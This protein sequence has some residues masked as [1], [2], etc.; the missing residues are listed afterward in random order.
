LRHWECSTVPSPGLRELSSIL[1]LELE[2]IHAQASELLLSEWPEIHIDCPPE[3]LL[4]PNL[5]VLKITPRAQEYEIL[6]DILERKPQIVPHLRKIM[7]SVQYRS[8]EMADGLEAAASRLN[9]SDGGRLS[10]GF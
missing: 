7:L 5:E 10:I 9:P 2:P 8:Q 3:C 4:A 1:Y 6:R